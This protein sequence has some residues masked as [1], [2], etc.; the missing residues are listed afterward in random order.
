MLV[1]SQPV[2][3]RSSSD[4]VHTHRVNFKRQG[5]IPISPQ[6]LWQIQTGWVRT[7][8]WDSDGNVTTLGIWGAGDIV[9]AP[10]SHIDPYQIICLSSVQAQILPGAVAWTT[11][12]LQDHIQQTETL[13]RLMHC[14]QL[15]QRLLLLLSWLSQRFGY[16]TTKG[17]LIKVQMTH[18]VMAETIGTSRV[19]VTKM[20][21]KLE[22]EGAI[23]RYSK[24]ILLPHS[25]P[26]DPSVRI[27]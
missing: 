14:K 10:P 6:H 25:Y 17:R 23:Q 24:T 4:S 7:L 18:Q 26:L 5:V 21:Q 3:E 27:E 20:L 15:P 22:Q 8:T 2:I 11:E 16:Y 19:T 9:G 1:S 12:N 13:L